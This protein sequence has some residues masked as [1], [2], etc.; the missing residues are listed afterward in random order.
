MVEAKLNGSGAVLD[1]GLVRLR[2]EPSR[3]ALQERIEAFDG[4]WRPVL[5][6]LAASGDADL[7]RVPRLNA[8]DVLS[9]TTPKEATLRLTGNANGVR[10]QVDATLGDGERFIRYRVTETR[11][12]AGRARSLQSRYGFASD[13]VDFCWAPHLRP[14][15]NDVVGQFSFKSP[16]IIVQ[17]DAQLAALVA[18]IK[19]IERDASQL[20]CLEPDMT[21]QPPMLA[22]G[23]KD[24]EPN[25]LIYFR[26]RAD[27]VA[28]VEPGTRTYGYLLYA[29]ATAEPLYGYREIVR[30]LWREFG[31]SSFDQVVPQVLPLR[32]L[33]RLRA[34]LRDS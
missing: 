12:R 19:T 31:E 29:S 23:F 6:S 28:T 4:E 24:H 27:M 8:V 16:A 20:V 5:E 1:N 11:E 3:D 34:R 22:Y 10:Y 7:D 32:P 13:L 21:A 17:R 26:H 2:V 18:D 25:G 9:T 30:L 14:R 15:E 33:R